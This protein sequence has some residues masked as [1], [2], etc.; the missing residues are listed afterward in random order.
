MPELSD[1]QAGWQALPELRAGMSDVAEDQRRIENAVRGMIST[2]EID[3][4]KCAAV[5]ELCDR[6]LRAD[7]STAPF[8]RSLATLAH[9]G[10]REATSRRVDE[11]QW[12][13][14]AQLLNESAGEAES[15]ARRG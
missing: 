13:A 14:L 10:A 9:Q 7:P 4:Q 2:Q 6:M 15:R 1:H 3:T 12:V 11:I 5:S 8:V